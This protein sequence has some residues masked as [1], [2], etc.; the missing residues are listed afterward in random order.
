MCCDVILSAKIYLVLYF[1]GPECP[2]VVAVLESM[3][4]LLY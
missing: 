4:L 1:F 2:V 3:F